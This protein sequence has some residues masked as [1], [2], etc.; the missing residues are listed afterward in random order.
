[1]SDILDRIVAAKRAEIAAG[2]SRRDL[3]SMRRAAEEGGSVRDFAAA[4]VGRV[5]RGEA[6]V[7]AEIKKA[8]PSK[9]VLRAD[10]RPA[11]IAASYERHGAAAL[12]VLTDEPFFQ[13]SA[14]YLAQARAACALPALRKDFIV[15]AWQVYESRAIGADAILLIA[16]VLDDVQMRDFE[17]LAEGLSMGVLVEVHDERELERALRLQTP[18]VGIN[19]RDLKTF[20]VS[21][22][23]TLR[24]LTA[25][26]GGRVVVTESGIGSA[27]DVGRLRRAGVHGFLIGETLM[28]AVDPGSALASLLS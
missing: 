2:K 23:T 5:R 13:G 12:S 22:E 19:N 26:P 21:L 16:A 7:I 4:I 8:S 17:A 18:L 1:M 14:A 27:G 28:K 25:V 9:G 15:D 6:A 11:E 20:E 24:M 10:F 3:A